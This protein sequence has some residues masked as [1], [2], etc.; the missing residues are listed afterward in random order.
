MSLGLMVDNLDQAADTL[1]AAASRSPRHPGGQG[2]R[3]AFF[4]DPDQTPLYLFERMGTGASTNA[5][6]SRT[7]RLARGP[8]DSVRGGLSPAAARGPEPGHHRSVS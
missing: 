8:V 3:F 4:H 6:S 5:V 7:G 2:A 1:R